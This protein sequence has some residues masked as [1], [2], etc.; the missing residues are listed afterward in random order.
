MNPSEKGHEQVE[1]REEKR[2]TRRDFVREAGVG[3]AALA[4][5]AGALSAVTAEAQQSAAATRTP[6]LQR[7]DMRYWPARRVCLL[8]SA[9]IRAG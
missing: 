5:A 3:A 9:R 2:I 7:S 8:E 1:E 4:G 6:R